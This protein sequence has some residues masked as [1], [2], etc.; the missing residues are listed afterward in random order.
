MG[1]IIQE[2]RSLIIA[3]DFNSKRFHEVLTAT[4]NIPE[5]GG[6]KG[7]PALTGR[8]GYDAMVNLKNTYAT[9]KAFIFDGQKWGTD[10]PDT[11]GPILTPLK[12]SGFDAVILF[13]QAG[14]ATEKAWIKAAQDLELGVIVG[15]KMTHPGFLVSDG[16]YIK[17]SAVGIIYQIAADLGV[18]NF[19]VPG[20][21]PNFIK[22]VRS[23]LERMDVDPTFYAPGFVAQGGEITEGA[24][25]A[26]K[27][28]HAIVGRAIYWN[29]EKERY[30][31]I[32]EMK[33]ATLNL[34]SQLKFKISLY[35]YFL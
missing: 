17:D 4:Y 26:G 29:K 11:A 35:Y 18:T 33:H 22:S 2:D 12:E 10:I 25:A 34:T 13:P 31:T 3:C 6:Y 20:N 14:P 27:R 9:D 24:K 5:V 23:E 19:V 28:F 1:K 7:G 21:D 8:P 16:G 32:D 30:N 15:G